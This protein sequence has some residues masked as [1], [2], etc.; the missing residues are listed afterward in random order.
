M[1][2]TD[3]CNRKELKSHS[4]CM[5][6]TLPGAIGVGRSFTIAPDCTKVPDFIGPT[7]L[8]TCTG[9][10]ICI[11]WVRPSLS[12]FFH[13]LIPSRQMAIPLSGAYWSE[14]HVFRF[15]IYPHRLRPY[16]L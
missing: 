9:A 4:L 10:Y 12:A 14:Q 3:Y 8:W 1:P 15:L 16:P 7:R 5:T 2:V 13:F 11:G 6:G